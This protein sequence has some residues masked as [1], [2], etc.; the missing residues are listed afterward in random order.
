MLLFRG[1]NVGSKVTQAWTKGYVAHAAILVRLEGY[2]Q[3]LFLFDAVMVRGVN[4]ASWD[5][6]KEKGKVY[7]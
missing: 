4:F 5:Y 2:D 3:N 1:S 7:N 6:F